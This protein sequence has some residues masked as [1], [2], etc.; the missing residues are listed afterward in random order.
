MSSM[1][2]EPLLAFTALYASY[3]KFFGMSNDFVLF[4]QFLPLEWLTKI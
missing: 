2:A 4:I 3:T 1:P